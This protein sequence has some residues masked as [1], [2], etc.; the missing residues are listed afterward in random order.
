[1]NMV[2]QKRANHGSPAEESE[3]KGETQHH[4]HSAPQGETE[5]GE[6]HEKD[7]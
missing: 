2:K 1:M 5:M 3:T 4:P 7:G 6:P